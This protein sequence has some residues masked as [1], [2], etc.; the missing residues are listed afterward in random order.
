MASFLLFWG[1]AFPKFWC[2]LV[3][4]RVGFLHKSYCFAYF[5]AGFGFLSG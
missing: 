4:A 1:I 2:N 5:Q 3:V